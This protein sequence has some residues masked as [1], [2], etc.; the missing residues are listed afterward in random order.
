M[1]VKTEA[2]VLRAR[3]FR[4]TSKILAL[5]TKEFGKISVI[6]KGARGPKNKFG[7]ALQPFAHVMAVVYKHSHRDLHLLSQCDVI[8]EFRRLPE[9]IDKFTASMSILELVGHVAHDEDRNVEFFDLLLTSL[10][11]MNDATKNAANIRFYFEI[12]LSDILGFRPNFVSCCGCGRPVDE[13]SAGTKGEELRLGSG[14]VLCNECS[15]SSDLG[16]ISAGSINILQRLQK[17]T[18]PDIV[19]HM[20]PS[21]HQTHEVQAALARY[22]QAHVGGLHKLRARD[23]ASSMM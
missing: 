10:R 4:D 20:S 22:L 2:I 3:K 9:D 15:S 23:V 1:I 5:Y 18:A 21:G 12:H 14:G 16:G 17:A 8:T 6:A 19:T 7:A 13:L 11:A